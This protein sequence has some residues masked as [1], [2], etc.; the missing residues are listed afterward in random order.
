M[1]T[2]YDIEDK[3]YLAI[4]EAFHDAAKKM[5]YID[6]VF[7]RRMVVKEWS[8]LMQVVDVALGNLLMTDKLEDREKMLLAFEKNLEELKEK[9]GRTSVVK[10][11]EN[12][13]VTVESGSNN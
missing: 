9:T 1:K 13:T 12:G 11:T 3:H 6:N 7:E 2:K 5:T 8:E 10:I 4:V